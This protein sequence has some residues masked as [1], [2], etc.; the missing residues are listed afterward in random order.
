MPTALDGYLFAIIVSSADPLPLLSVKDG[1]IWIR[2]WFPLASSMQNNF[3]P[4]RTVKA[5][6]V[7][8]TSAGR[9]LVSK[10][11]GHS[12][13]VIPWL[14]HLDLQRSGRPSSSSTGDQPPIPE[15]PSFARASTRSCLQMM[16]LRPAVRGTGEKYFTW[17]GTILTTPLRCNDKK[18]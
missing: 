6:I 14:Y 2:V 18:L 3:K 16:H 11:R 12:A 17:V 10:I 5:S 7:E 4:I 13:P 8:M 15:R 1:I 9:S